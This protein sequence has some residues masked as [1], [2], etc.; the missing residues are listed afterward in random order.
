MSRFFNLIKYNH[1][2]KFKSL[3]D[4]EIDEITSSEALAE[5]CSDML[6]QY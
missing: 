3:S 6:K 5:I 4:K 2:D 1:S